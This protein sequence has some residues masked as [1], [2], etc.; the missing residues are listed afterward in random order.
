MK[1]TPVA[2]VWVIATG[3]VGD[4]P[5]IK[6]YRT[7]I[8]KPDPTMPFEVVISIGFNHPDALGLPAESETDTLQTFDAYLMEELVESKEG[9]LVYKQTYDS[10]QMF[11]FYTKTDLYDRLWAIN[12]ISPKEYEVRIDV[13]MDPEWTEF[14]RVVEQ[15]KAKTEQ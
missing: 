13:D 8:T 2:G 3:Q 9:L 1:E 4:M 5:I 7:D 10:C 15:H 14:M 12:R 11:L 6:R